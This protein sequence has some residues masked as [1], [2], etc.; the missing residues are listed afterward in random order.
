LCFLVTNNTILLTQLF[1]VRLAID[2]E[3][4]EKLVI[5]ARQ[6]QTSVR[7]ESHG[8]RTDM[9][10]SEHKNSSTAWHNIA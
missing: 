9:E 7:M 1:L 3:E 5:T 4:A 10:R 6:Q 8:Y 2:A